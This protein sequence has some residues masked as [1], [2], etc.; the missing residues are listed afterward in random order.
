MTTKQ[1]FSKGI[2]YVLPWRL[3]EV[4]SATLGG[5]HH[6]PFFTAFRVSLKESI[7]PQGILDYKGGKI[8]MDLSSSGELV[9]LRACQKEPETVKW[10]ETHLKPGETFYDIGANVGAYSFVAHKVSGG[11]STIYALEPSFSTFA[12]LCRNIMLNHCD[13]NIVP[14]QIAL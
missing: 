2:L 7:R 10:I 6:V 11:K 9:R 5:R 13:G 3:R 4:L 14:L 8:F 12:A 1:K